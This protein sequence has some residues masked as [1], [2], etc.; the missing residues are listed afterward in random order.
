MV[1]AFDQIQHDQ[2]LQ[3]Y[4]VK[5]GFAALIDVILILTPV[6]V[7]LGLVFVMGGSFMAMGG[8]V[9][10]FV[11][12][13]YSAFFEMGVGATIGKMLLGF[14]VVSIE[15]KLEPSQLMVRNVTKVFALL[16]VVDMLLAFLTET[17]DPRQRYMDRMAK[18]VLVFEKAH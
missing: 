6:Y 3:D 7:L 16:A 12:F 4:W 9:L 10:G 1:I 17:S 11:W 18:T 5:R 15:G 13:L 8:I 14:R 2:A